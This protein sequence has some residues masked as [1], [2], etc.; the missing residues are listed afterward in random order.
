MSLTLYG[1]PF[2]VATRFVTCT[3]ECLD[4]EYEFRHVDVR[5]GEHLTPEFKKVNPKQTLPCLVDGSFVLTESHAIAG[6]L[7]GQHGKVGE[8]LYPTDPMDRARVDE[9]MYFDATTI[10]RRYQELMVS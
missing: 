1:D 3:M 8:V 4:L 2:S 10:S 9:V 7:A 5:K 6:Y